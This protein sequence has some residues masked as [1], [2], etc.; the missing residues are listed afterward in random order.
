MKNEEINNTINEA[1]DE[2]FKLIN[3]YDSA[4]SKAERELEEGLDK[5][6]SKTWCNTEIMAAADKDL[7]KLALSEFRNGLRAVERLSKRKN[8][9][10]NEI[11]DMRIFEGLYAMQCLLQN[12]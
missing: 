1:G 10:F 6:E 11:S 9:L 4:I 8:D 7:V 5:I 3:A 2:V 12:K